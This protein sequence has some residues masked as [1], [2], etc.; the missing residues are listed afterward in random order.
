MLSVHSFLFLTTTSA[1][2]TMAHPASRLSFVF[3]PL[4]LIQDYHSSGATTTTITVITTMY[5]VNEEGDKWTVSEVRPCPLFNV[6]S[7]LTPLPNF[8]YL[9][10]NHLLRQHHRQRHQHQWAQH[11][12]HHTTMGH[13]HNKG[14]DGTTTAMATAG[15]HHH[16][17]GSEGTPAAT[18]P[19]PL[20]Q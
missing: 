17:E 12:H 13:H 18:G 10:L 19:P 14:G 8:I 3:N 2:A 15:H 16:H 7:L 1:A 11:H 4:L 9:L 5:R 6:H 20:Q